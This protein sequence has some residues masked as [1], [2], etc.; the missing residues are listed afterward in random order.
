MHNR[1]RSRRP[2]PPDLFAPLPQRPTW[3]RLPPEVTQQVTELLA[4]LLRSRHVR[5]LL[6]AARKGGADE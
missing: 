5:G 4:Q 1:R 6:P 3:D 2:A